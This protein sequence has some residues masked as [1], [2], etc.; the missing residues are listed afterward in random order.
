MSRDLRGQIGAILPLVVTN[1]RAPRGA[2][3]LRGVDHGWATVAATQSQRSAHRVVLDVDAAG[4]GP[5]PPQVQRM[6]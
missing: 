5:Q 4:D 6:R 1:G 3:L 2:M